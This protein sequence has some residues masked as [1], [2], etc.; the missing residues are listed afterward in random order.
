MASTLVTSNLFSLKGKVAVVTGGGT[1]I[2]LMIARGFADNGA[3]TYIGSRRKEV[4]EKAAK[5]YQQASEGG[6]QLIP[7]ELDV[8][9][10]TSIR[11]AV[12]QIESNGAGKVDI[13]VNK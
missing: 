2:G 9:D 11:N 12:S 6:G 7:I 8:T 5:E 3:K 10:K 4:V 1:G 13:L